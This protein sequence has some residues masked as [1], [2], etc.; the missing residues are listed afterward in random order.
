L[1]GSRAALLALAVPLAGLLLHRNVRELLIGLVP[2]LRELVEPCPSLCVGS[3][4]ARC[5]LRFRA[6]RCRGHANVALP[7]GV[8]LPCGSCPPGR[9]RSGGSAVLAKVVDVGHHRVVREAEL[10]TGVHRGVPLHELPPSKWLGSAGLE[11]KVG[12]VVGGEPEML[13]R[14]VWPQHADDHLVRE[15]SG[16]SFTPRSPRQDVGTRWPGEG[17]PGD[18]L[19]RPGVD[20]AEG[21]EA[22]GGPRGQRDHAA[23]HPICW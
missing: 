13:L 2:G 6:A 20:E 15:G 3:V 1:F 18:G 12:E 8:A 16:E 14:W 17:T 19:Y 7:R 21:A 22:Q 4:V 9:R 10:S 5:W 11:G 23:V